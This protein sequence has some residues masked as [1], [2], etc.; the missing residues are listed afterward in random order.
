MN[1]RG[2]LIFWF[3]A[4][5]A[6]LVFAWKESRYEYFIPLTR[7]SVL[8]CEGERCDLAVDTTAPSGTVAHQGGTI[9]VSNVSRYGISGAKVFGKGNPSSGQNGEQWFLLSTSDPY[10]D[11]RLFASEP[12]LLAALKRDGI[13]A[14]MLTPRF[15]QADWSSIG[16]APRLAMVAAGGM[17]AVLVIRA[18]Y[19]TRRRRTNGLLK[20]E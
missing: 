4:V 1:W 7:N 14:T 11:V 10:D 5:G 3:I 12:E 20:A 8:S 17:L 9:F 16:P 15:A 18:R 6:V 19:W 2:E 13:A